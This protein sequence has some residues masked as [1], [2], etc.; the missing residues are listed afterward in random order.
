MEFVSMFLLDALVNTLA[1]TLQDHVFQELQKVHRV[2]DELVKLQKS[3]SSIQAVLSDAQESEETRNIVKQ[4]LN[5]LRDVAYRANDILDDVATE[6]QRQQLIN[7]APV[8]NFFGPV[9]LMRLLFQ[10]DVYHKIQS[11]DEEL[12]KIVKRCPLIALSPRNRSQ[13]THS[14]ESTPAIPPCVLGRERDKQKIKELLVPF[15][16]R[17]DSAASVISIF[18]MPGVGKTTLAQ[19]LFDDETVKKHFELRLWVYVSHDFDLMRIMRCMI[20]S[21]DGFKCD[22]TSLN[23]LQQEVRKKV[24]R[25]R[26]LLVL[27]NVWQESQE[28][29]KLKSF[30]Y[31]ADEGSKILVTTKSEQ[32]ARFMAANSPPYHLEGLSMDD[33]WSLICQQVLS[34]NPSATFTHDFSQS[35]AL[36]RCMGLPMAAK[37]LGERLAREA[38]RS[39]W[40][41]ILTSQSW[42]FSG[43]GIS[44]TETL[45]LSYQHLPHYLKPCFEYLSIIPKGFKL[46]RDFII[47]LWMAQSFIRPKGTE[48][49]EDVGS[50]YLDSLRSSSFLQYSHFDHKSRR[51]R[52]V[53]HDVFHEFARHVAAEECSVMEP[54]TEPSTDLHLS[55]SARVR[56]LSVN[57]EE[58]VRRV[59]RGG[60]MYE[61]VYKCKGLQSLLLIGNSTSRP[62]MVVPDNL[63]QRL[64]SLRTLMLTNSCLTQLPESIG[65]LSHLRCLQLQNTGI[66]RLPDSVSRLYNLQTLGLRNCYDLEELP[67]DMSKLRNLRHLDLHLDG[68]SQGSNAG[69]KLRLMP[70]EIGLLTHLRTLSRFVV[71]KRHECGLS[72]LENLNDLR[73]D[74]LIERLDLVSSGEDAK[75]ANLWSKEHIHRLELTWNYS[76]VTEASASS[77]GYNSRE[78]ILKY[79]RPHNKLKEIGVVGYGGTLLPT[80]MGDS[81]LENLETVWISKTYSCQNLPPLGQLPKLK[82]LFLEEMHGLKHIDCSFCGRNEIRFPKLEKLHLE[83]MSGLQEWLGDHRCALPSLRELTINNCPALQQLTHE[84]PSLT[85]LVIEA[86]PYFAG[87]PDFPKLQSLEVKTNDDWIWR[88]CATISSLPSLTLSGLRRANLPSEISSCHS[89]IRRLEIS[90]C[91]QLIFIPDGWLPAFLSHFVIRH[92]PKLQNLPAELTRLTRLEDLEIEKCE[93]LEQLPFGL[94]NMNLLAHLEISDCPGLSWLHGL[95]RNLQFLSISNCPEL[96]QKLQDQGWFTRRKDL[97]VWINGHRLDFMKISH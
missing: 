81:S 50:D 3:V 54:S 32:V 41:A 48:H 10:R 43:A 5:E 75:N 71:S 26:Y 4:L 36:R 97:Q 69:G 58:L 21:I 19:Q 85:K 30:L 88:S 73:S 52:Y 72:Q 49:M 51:Q 89:F 15:S 28:W 68:N 92:C 2:G 1:D 44:I 40:E 46:E 87:L 64:R 91:S 29:E 55:L 57:Y 39:K 14:S 80:W 42:E 37:A 38:D 94:R 20:E 84:L 70:P 18:G 13:R 9:N 61:Q 82:Y 7:Y 16:G 78:N 23:N 24:S 96:S 60:D 86:S 95:P 93:K 67:K 63:A 11:I 33:C 22:L 25:R 17:T 74:L 47:Q 53:M 66:K 35:H 8:R 77:A 45:S 31:S 34:R 56:H 6:Q 12:D 27:D 62:T 90:Y 59:P 83:N 65:D 76:D 79:L